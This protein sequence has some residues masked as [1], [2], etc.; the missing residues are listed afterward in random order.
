VFDFMLHRNGNIIFPVKFARNEGDCATRHKFP[1]ENHA[2]PP[3]VRRFSPHVETQIHFFE[4][5]VQR[6]WKTQEPCI[7]K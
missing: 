6:N 2:A 3:C 7:E 4:I 5:A 1:D